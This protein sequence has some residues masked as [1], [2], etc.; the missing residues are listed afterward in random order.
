MWL[1]CQNDWLLHIIIIFLLTFKCVSLRKYTD[2]NLYAKIQPLSLCLRSLPF[3]IEYLSILQV[4]LF[5]K[6]LALYNI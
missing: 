3:Q 4:I 5:S 2:T 6:T 1:L